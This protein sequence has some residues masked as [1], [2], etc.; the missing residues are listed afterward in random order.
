[1]I[2]VFAA[3]VP[4]GDFTLQPIAFGLAIGVFVDAFVVRMTLVPAVMALL[5]ERAWWLPARLDRALP[6]FDV[7]GEGLARQLDL[8]DWPSPAA[9]P[10]IYAESLTLTGPEAVSFR[11]V[12][13]AVAPGQ[14]LRVSGG[15]AAARAA[16]LLTLAGRVT[17]TSGRL[18]VAGLVVPEQSLLVRRRV[19]LV[20]AADEDGPDGLLEALPRALRRSTAVLLV[21]GLERLEPVAAERVVA[22]V[23]RHCR[24]RDLAGVVAGAALGGADPSLDITT[25]LRADLAALEESR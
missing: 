15:S 11:D 4:E 3:F 18:K 5:G 14:V 25:G 10:G 7:E 12:D 23:I 21:D 16:L 8:A 2:A 1:M 6:S 19:A 20:R 22:A 24:D 9:P 13:L 17:P